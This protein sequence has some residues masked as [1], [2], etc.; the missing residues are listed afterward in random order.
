M[1]SG[2]GD[3][4]R[5]SIL[6]KGKGRMTD[7]LGH[8]DRAY[9]EYLQHQVYA[10][11]LGL[12]ILQFHS[13][14]SLRISEP[15]LNVTHIL[16]SQSE[17]MSDLG[18]DGDEP[19]D[20]DP[21]PHQDFDFDPQM[22]EKL[23][24][25]KHITNSHRDARAKSSSQAQILRLESLPDYLSVYYAQCLKIDYD[26][27]MCCARVKTLLYELYDEYLRVYGPSLNI[28]V[29]QTQNASR[30]SSSS[31]GFFNLGYN[32]LSKKTKKLRGSS[33]SSSTTYSE[34]ESYL[35]TSF[36]FIE[37][38]ED[39]KF[40]ILHWWNEYE[41]YFPILAMIAKQIL[42]TPVSMVAVEQQF[43]AG[44]NI[45]DPKRSLMS[46]KSLQIQAC[47]EDWTKA[48]YRQQE[49]DQDDQDEPFHF[50]KDDQPA[51]SRTDD[52]GND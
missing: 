15:D 47:V 44:G 36:E 27:D 34:L 52:H 4:P 13:H 46:P 30:S 41:R 29:P 20:P 42:S 33:S 1:A 38:T 35:S 8:D 14:P 7:N 25:Q 2:S 39:K 49:I 26:I 40:D 6:M 31:S 22:E 18:H 43:S 9:H 51:E 24:K 32:L 11:D 17:N 10:E 45:L 50:F 12:N 21:N 48:Q 37:D 16:T 28:D 19:D 5:R 3:A 23:P